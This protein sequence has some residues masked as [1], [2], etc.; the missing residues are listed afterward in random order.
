MNEKLHPLANVLNEA[1]NE[2]LEKEGVCVLSAV[3]LL[4]S[5]AV[6]AIRSSVYNP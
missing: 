6:N 3:S 1:I 2:E 4:E 5:L